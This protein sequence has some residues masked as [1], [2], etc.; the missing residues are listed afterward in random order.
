MTSNL[1]PELVQVAES[2]GIDP[3]ALVGASSSGPSVWTGSTTRTSRGVGR[4]DRDA[5]VGAVRRDVLDTVRPVDDVYLDFY[6]WDQ[7][8]LDRFQEEAFTAGFYG[9]NDR[10]KVRFGDRDEG[11]FDIWRT[12]VDRA[13]NFWAVDQKKTPHD[14]FAE[15]VK[16]PNQFPGPEPEPLTVVLSNPADIKDAMREAARDA[17]GK[18]RVDEDR[19]DEIVSR[20]Q[21]MER[22][23][24]QASHDAAE[25]GGTVTQ[26]PSLGSFVEDEA[27]RLDPTAAGAHDVLDKFSML[28]QMLRGGG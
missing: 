17:I 3:A 5:P 2:L 9:T 21:Q 24:Q 22:S 11:T 13:A 16:I 26:P 12:M 19:L 18:G 7:D 15:A 1:P 20:Y 27:R 28:E 25:D 14:V 6:R 10:S 4:M 23:A 8:D